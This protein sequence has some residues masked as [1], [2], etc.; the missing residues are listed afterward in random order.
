MKPFIDHKNS[1]SHH[2]RICN[3]RWCTLQENNQNASLSKRN[4][5]GVKGVSFNKQCKKWQALISVDRKIIHIG[6][7]STLEEAKQARIKSVT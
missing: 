2:N 3:L 6:F 1:I 5:S 4:T 7:F